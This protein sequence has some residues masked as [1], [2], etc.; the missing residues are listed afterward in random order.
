MTKPG[1]ETKFNDY[2][3]RSLCMD[4][5]VSDGLLGTEFTEIWV[6]IGRAQQVMN[7]YQD[8]FDEGGYAAT[9]YYSTEVY[10]GPPSSS[11]MHPGYTNGSDEY[12]DGS[13]RIDVYWFRDNMGVPNCDEGFLDQY[14]EVLR[15]NDVPFRLH[16]GKFIPRYDFAEWAALYKA[17][18]PRFEDFMAVRETRD[19]DGLF[20]TDYW[21]TRLT[22]SASPRET[23]LK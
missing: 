2:Y 3:W 9:G 20:F 14:W 15:D 23:Q 16:W 19:P 5:T 1:E 11:W 8:M 7:L 21:Q 18:L 12:K 10:G 13:V 17:N 22:G 4:N 6:P